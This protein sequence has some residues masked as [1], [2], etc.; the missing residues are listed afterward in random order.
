M[1]TLEEILQKAE[2]LLQPYAQSSSRPETNR[3][4]VY[5]ARENLIP[6]IKVLVE[7]R[8]G[9]LSTITGIDRPAAAVEEGQS[10]EE[11]EIEVLYSFCS[12]AAIV[13]LRVRVP[14]ADAVLPSICP[15]IPSATLGER[16]LMEMFGVKVEGTPDTSRLILADSWPEGVYPLRKSFVPAARFSGGAEG[17]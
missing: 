13:N 1:S 17:G 4:D 11:G 3:L 8:W 10:P 12:G 9:Y 2:N 14:Y 6:A 15:L 7:A 5:L 16:E